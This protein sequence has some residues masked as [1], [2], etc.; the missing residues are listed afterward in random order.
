MLRSTVVF[1]SLVICLTLFTIVSVAQAV[2]ATFNVRDFGAVGDGTTSD[3]AAITK[4][5][6]ACNANGGGT[7][8]FPAGKYMT[9][10]FEL[11]S[12]VNLHLE[13]G[14]VI[15]GSPNLDD[16]GDVSLLGI[17]KGNRVN[18]SGE[19]TRLGIIFARKAENISITGEGAIDGRGDDF[20]DLDVPHAGMD[21]DPKY[22]RNPEGM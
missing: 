20:M 18:V 2:P 15:L 8:L 14:A 6:K 11:L 16:Y 10:S 9:G 13:A 21:F 7:V 12:N 17:G 4:A 1:L 3:N 5:I 19:G 22:V